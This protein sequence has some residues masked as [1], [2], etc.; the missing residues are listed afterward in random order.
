MGGRLSTARVGIAG[1]LLASTL[2]GCVPAAQN[3]P[4]AVVAAFRPGTDGKAV[5]RSCTMAL[6]WTR[7][8]LFEKCGKP[9]AITPDATLDGACYVYQ[10]IARRLA[11]D[12]STG[13]AYLVA[14]T[15]KRPAKGA[16]KSVTT[17]T[18]ES[19]D[20][21]TFVTTTT[22]TTTPSG[23]GGDDLVERVARISGTSQGPTGL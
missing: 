15:E 19:R 11:G 17:Q 9:D 7:E 20:D 16:P 22:V 10:T 5:F 2:G 23:K 14:C 12:G 13:T 1:V 4:T 18:R 21:G 3:V 6:G 8:E